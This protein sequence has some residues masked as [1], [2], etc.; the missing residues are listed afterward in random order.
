MMLFA[1]V[2][3]HLIKL[4]LFWVMSVLNFIA[5][6]ALRICLESE[7]GLVLCNLGLLISLLSF[8]DF[9][10]PQLLFFV[11]DLLHVILPSVQL[12]I[13]SWTW[14][15]HKATPEHSRREA[16]DGVPHDW[17][18]MSSAESCQ[19]PPI[20]HIEHVEQYKD[21]D[22][23]EHV[24]AVVFVVLFII[25]RVNCEVATELSWKRWFLAAGVSL[26]LIS[27]SVVIYCIVVVLFLHVW[28]DLVV[29]G[30][31]LF[32]NQLINIL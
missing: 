13:G 23:N 20:E 3:S 24:L 17:L 12:V 16:G 11:V 28:L 18:R 9:S 6:L 27:V 2:V 22:Y 30:N 15:Y 4:L 25:T 10:L 21:S 14:E 8:S 19:A 1:V 7:L 26:V 31:R 32:I 29:Q 5:S